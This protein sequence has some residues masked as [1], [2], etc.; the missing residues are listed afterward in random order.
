MA[1]RI[2]TRTGRSTRRKLLPASGDGASLRLATRPST[3]KTRTGKPI[4]PNAPSGS[5]RKIL[6]SIQVSFQSPRSII[7]GLLANRVTSQFE[8]DVLQVGEDCAEIRDSNPILG[9]TMNHLGH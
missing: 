8:K 3:R 1:M 6:I 9:Q 7:S 5:R 2:D 4:V